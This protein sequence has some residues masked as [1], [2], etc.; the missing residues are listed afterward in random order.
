MESR[1]SIRPHVWARR[2]LDHY[3]FGRLDNVPDIA[4][5]HPT[6][7]EDTRAVVL[8]IYNATK[9][10]PSSHNI[11]EVNGLKWLFRSGQT[12]KPEQAKGSATRRTPCSARS[13]PGGRMCPEGRSEVGEARSAGSAVP[14]TGPRPYHGALRR[15]LGPERAG[16]SS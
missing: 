6:L 16:R 8:G 7:T 3:R 11:V 4:F 12:W 1:C 5:G 10:E 15:S 2:L 13:A 9:D 14:A